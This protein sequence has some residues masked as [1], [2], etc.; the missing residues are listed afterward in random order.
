MRRR[1]LR[2]PRLF[3]DIGQTLSGRITAS[4]LRLVMTVLLARVLTPVQYGLVALLLNGGL[5]LSSVLEMGLGAAFIERES[6]EDDAPLVRE[7][8]VRLLRGRFW[9]WAG[10]VLVTTLVLFIPVKAKT[11]VLAVVVFGTGQNL[12]VSFQILYQVRQDF[13]KYAQ[14]SVLFAFAQVMWAG[15][16]LAV[17]RVFG[18]PFDAFFWGM[19]ALGWAPV[20]VLSKSTGVALRE[21]LRRDW[22][23]DFA[24]IRSLL[25]F[26]KWVGLTTIATQTFSRYAVIL[27]GAV[28]AVAEAGRYDIAMT[29]GRSVNN[30][31]IS[32][33][34][35]LFPRFAQQRK[36]E[37]MRRSV[38]NV[39]KMAGVVVL[40]GLLFYYLAG[41]WLV[42]LLFGENY[43]ASMTY[44]DILMPGLLLPILLEPII[45]VVTFSMSQPRIVFAIRAIKLAVFV[46]FGTVVL[47]RFGVAGVAGFQT[48]LA[49]GETVAFL[50]FV[51]FWLERR[52]ESGMPG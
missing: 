45:G 41:R 46:A 51:L 4:L 6:R 39:L 30:I 52:R 9:L 16:L 43:R 26:G 23:S 25:R 21:L 10:F 32:T 34:A 35:V 48:I 17:Y 42:L 33:T 31:V 19:A 28:E 13:G 37:D 40:V 27:L 24:Y 20:L 38:S 44:L 22:S 2:V 12:C 14:I 3:R 36:T 1:A 47:R 7:R 29:V 15:L 50:V 5:L 11:L 18:L 49:I 8:F